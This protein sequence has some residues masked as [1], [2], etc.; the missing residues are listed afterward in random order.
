MTDGL[1]LLVTSVDLTKLALTVDEAFVATRLDGRTTV[2]AVAAMVG[3]DAATVARIVRKLA[4]LGAVTFQAPARPTASRSTFAPP[5][6]AGRPSVS[7]PTRSSV[8][9]GSPAPGPSAPPKKPSAP[10]A[11]PGPGLG[12]VS[13]PAPGSAAAPA[14]GAPPKPGPFVPNGDGP[15]DYGNYVFPSGQL[16][17]PSDL[18]VEAKKRILYW[19]D[20]MD[21]WSHYQLLG[22]DR[23]ADAK[24]I[25]TAYF[26][27][28]KDWHP[29]RF[30]RFKNLGV[31]GKMVEAIYKR[32]SMA[33]KIL[34]DDSARADYDKALPRDLDAVDIAE[35]LMEQ[36]QAERDQRREE[37]RH[38]RR[39]KQN[40][41]LARFAR[42]KEFYDQAVELE[43]GGKLAEAMRA[44]QMATTYDD[45][46][47]EF[48][49]LFERLRDLAG[50]E[51]IIPYIRRG[52]HFETMADWEEAL[53]F[54]EEAVRIAPHNGECRVR[55]AYTLLHA[56]RPIEEVM[57][58][59]QKSLQLAPED[60]ESHYVVARCY[61]D[62]GNEKGAKRHYERA[63][64]LRPGFAEAQKRLKRLKWG[65]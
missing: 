18:D 61:E 7:A 40:P 29:D 13:T 32:V 2:D 48:R 20:Q 35:L 11:R 47:V 30:K 5:G 43:K 28:S 24:T 17:E 50:D 42:A 52:R 16:S 1:P 46:K 4:D 33:Y 27:R 8:F 64:E 22:V 25:K 9:P 65:F 58:H 36:I 41:V 45:R 21:A 44:A 62:R 51:R 12:S 56:G 15:H 19:S 31:F 54:Y 6:P 38:A 34:G 10:P 26:D 39:L 23:K 53:S 60:A 3:K 59:A 49:A 55:Y 14:G 37:E 57:P 63:L